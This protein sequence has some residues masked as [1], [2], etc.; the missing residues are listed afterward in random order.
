MN[1]M[2]PDDTVNINAPLLAVC[3]KS[4]G[5][6]VA[7]SWVS[8]WMLHTNTKASTLKTQINPRAELE[9]NVTVNMIP[10][11]HAMPC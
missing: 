4:K 8:N 10:S 2:I 9:T 3:D 11:L 6:T 5:C 1:P 7:C